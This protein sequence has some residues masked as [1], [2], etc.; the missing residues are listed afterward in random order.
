MQFA[1]SRIRIAPNHHRSW[2]IGAGSAAGFTS[3][4]AHAGGPPIAVYLMTVGLEPRR[5]VTTSA[6][7]FAV[8]NLIKVPGYF[9]A[10]IF[11]GELILSTIWSWVL[12]PVGVGLGRLLVTR[13][14]RALFERVLLVL[15][16]IGLIVLLVR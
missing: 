5:F 12:I 4:V 8:I 13:I 2:G 11:D 7:Y 14:D 9:I 6:A 1:T 16:G 10:D 15:L 3:T